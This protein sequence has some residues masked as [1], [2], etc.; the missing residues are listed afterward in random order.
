MI[1]DRRRWGEG[2]ELGRKGRRKGAQTQEWEGQNAV[3][4]EERGR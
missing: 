3:E 4:G 2:K 1:S